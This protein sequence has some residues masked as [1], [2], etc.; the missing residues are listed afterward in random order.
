MDTQYESWAFWSRDMSKEKTERICTIRRR[1][2]LVAVAAGRGQRTEERADG[3]AG[4]AA[5]S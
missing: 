4:V 2:R 1:I 3:P 5:P